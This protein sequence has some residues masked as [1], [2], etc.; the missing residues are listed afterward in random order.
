MNRRRPQRWSRR[1]ARALMPRMPEQDEMTD[2]AEPFDEDE[3]EE[4]EDSEPAPTT[5][6]SATLLAAIEWDD[7]GKA[8]DGDLIGAE[9]IAAFAKR[10]PNRPGVYRMFDAEGDV[11]YVGKARSPE[12]ARRQLH[13]PRR[14]H[15]A[16]R[17]DDRAR[18]GTWSSSR[19]APRPRRC[20]SK[21]TS[22]SACGRASTCCCGTTSRS[23]TSWS[24]E[25]HE[26]PAIIK[27]RGA[28]SRKGNY[29]GPFASAGAVG[30]TINALQRA[31][32]LRSCS[33]SVYESRTR[34]CLLYQIK[35]CSAPAPA[36]SRREDYAGL[37]GEAKAFLSG[38]SNQIKSGMATAMQEASDDLDFERAALYRD[39]L[40]ALSHVQSHQG[41]NPQ[42]DRGGR[43]LRHP[44]GGRPD[45]H[46]GLLLP[47]RPEL[48]QP[49]LFPAR[50]TRRSSRTRCS[51]PSSPSSTTTSRR[52]GWSCCRS[53]SRTR[54]CS[55]RRSA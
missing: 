28:R 27:H 13:A 6:A 25:D 3:L 8:I 18:R 26:A 37:V 9:L 32:L 7:G 16:H 31:F 40:A 53:S 12:E 15:P 33:D 19:P 34:P 42:G 11:L 23:P 21:R 5:D 36:R 54:R 48:G 50:P 41:I 10:L 4:T 51:A 44:S 46:P 55:P 22:S 35:R 38:R 47:H 24:R 49:R 17:A 52:R 29:F 45:L 43:R 2:E 1:P 30:R 39:R 14:P 20:C